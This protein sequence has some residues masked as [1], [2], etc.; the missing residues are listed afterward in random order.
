MIAFGSIITKP[1]AYLQY[2][3]PGIELAAESDSE[4][5][6]FSSVGPIARG[7]NLL[8]DTAGNSDDLEALVLLHPHAEITDPDF[9]AKVRQALADPEVG[10][11]GAAGATGVQSLAWWEGQISR[12]GVTHRYDDYRGG[13]I[14]AYKWASTGPAPAEVEVIDGFLMVLAPWVVHNLRFDESLVLG[15]G[16]DVDICRQVRQAGR[17]VMTCDIQATHHHALELFSDKQSWVEAHIRLAEKWDSPDYGDDQDA[18]RARARRAEAE[19]EV[20][21]ARAYS[22]ELA[23]DAHVLGLERELEE[24]LDSTS[25]RLTAPLRAASASVRRWRGRRSD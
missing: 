3:R 4:V 10:L 22:R 5:F 8:M 17:K 23:A 6:A 21:R 9:C 24:A 13:R 1:E 12:G 7:C 18:W 19:R 25:W 20:A 2:A 15:H 11:V 14:A 16:F